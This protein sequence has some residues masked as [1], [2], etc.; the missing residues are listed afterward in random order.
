[1]TVTVRVAALKFKFT[2]MLVWLCLLWSRASGGTG[3]TPEF[4]T[5]A[6]VVRTAAHCW[7]KLKSR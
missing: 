4:E 6:T 2:F 3:G 1:M 5:V 7:V